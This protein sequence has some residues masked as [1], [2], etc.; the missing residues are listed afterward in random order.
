MSQSQNRE[1][2][3]RMYL[4]NARVAIGTQKN[5]LCRVQK[6]QKQGHAFFS[7]RSG[8]RR[9]LGRLWGKDVPGDHNNTDSDTI[10]DHIPRPTLLTQLQH[11]AQTFD[12][13]ILH[14][15][16]ETLSLF[17]VPVYGSGFATI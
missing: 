9:I 13:L 5:I 10:F 6:I 14:I 4:R 15:A 2:A 16:G 7:F 11:Y 8:C 1:L 3:L 17:Q 12:V